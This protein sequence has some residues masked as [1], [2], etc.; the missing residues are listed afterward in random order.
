[1][2]CRDTI[3]LICWYL[4]GRLSPAVEAE[5]DNHLRKCDDCRI[6]QE[7]A[8]TTLDREFGTQKP[9]GH[10]SQLPAVIQAA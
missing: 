2:S 3:H 5:I 7:A 8:T 4:E 6:V 10:R 1:M 9:S